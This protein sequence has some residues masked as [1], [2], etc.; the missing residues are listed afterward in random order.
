MVLRHGPPFLAFNCAQY[1]STERRGL[2]PFRSTLF[3]IFITVNMT[4][5]SLRSLYIIGGSQNLTTNLK[6]HPLSPGTSLSTCLAR[7]LASPGHASDRRSAA[8]LHGDSAVLDILS[9]QSRK[10]K[11]TNTQASPCLLLCSGKLSQTKAPIMID[12]SCSS[13]AIRSLRWIHRP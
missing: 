2:K 7:N 13:L 11:S 6:A 3:T 4:G 10:A 12:L 8:V 1:G 5:L 9:S